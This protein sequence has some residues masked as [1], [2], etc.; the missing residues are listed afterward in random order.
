MAKGVEDTAFYRYHRFVALNEVG[1]AP[2]RFGH[3]VD[4]FHAWAAETLE[5]RPRTLLATSTHDTKR[6]ED[7][8]MRLAVL[9]E[10]PDRWRDAV[11]RWVA[12]NERHRRGA[13][14]DRN[15]EYLLYQ[16]LVGA[17]PID[18]ARAKAFMQKAVR[19]AKLETSWHRPNGEYEQA[20]DAFV[21]AALS[22]PDFVA[23][24]DAFVAPLVAPGRINSLAFVLLKLTAPGVPDFYRG[25]ELW[26][27]SL[28]DPDN[29]RPVDYDLRRRLL[30][31]LDRLTP[32][33]ILARQDE[34]L[35]K[36]WLIRQGLRV[37]R[38]Y[39]EAFAAGAYRPIEAGGA[40]REHVI[41][42]RRGEAI[43][44]V[45]PRWPLSVGGDWQDTHI[46]MPPGD[47]RN[48][49]TGDEWHG[50]DV[51]VA[52]LLRRFPVALLAPAGS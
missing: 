42:F 23:D 16:T 13:W 43:V 14:P 46:T 9:S 1:G 27:L 35:P 51:R 15:V 48:A 31:E 19:E 32:E 6:S 18:A 10:I 45:A 37:R 38:A 34:G 21:S 44:S 50:G 22:A 39:A 4:E 33:E 3:A 29:R 2:D 28:V 49:L 5:Q 12:M 25:T 36:L 7:V 8:R 26:D 17:W 41:A 47:W 30:R 20:L 24:L 40:R 11:E 52:D